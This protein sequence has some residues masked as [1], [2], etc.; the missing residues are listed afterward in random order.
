MYELLLWME[1]TP[2]IML[3]RRK[4]VSIHTESLP[5]YYLKVEHSSLVSPVPAV[6]LVVPQMLAGLEESCSPSLKTTDI[7]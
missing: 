7:L 1:R 5:I 6:G 2:K 4:I 3:S